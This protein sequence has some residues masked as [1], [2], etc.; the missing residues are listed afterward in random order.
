M[1]TTESTALAVRDL[2]TDA[3]IQ[4]RIKLHRSPGFGLERA[5][6]AALNILFLY[7]QKH[8]LLP[9]DDV[10]LYDGKPFLQIGGVV[11]AMRRHPEYR[12]YACRPLNAADKEAWGYDAGDI[13]IECTIRTDRWGEITA[14]GKVSKDEAAGVQR[15]G[16]RL[17]PVARL[18]PVE[19]AEKRAIAR[20]QR[21]AF[22]LDAVVDEEEFEQAAQTVITERNDP[23]RIAAGAA[24][25]DEVIPPNY[26]EDLPMAITAA[27]ETAPAAAETEPEDAELLQVARER[28]ESACKEAE[29]IGVKGVKQLRWAKTDTI[30][31]IERKTFETEERTR[32]RNNELDLAAAQSS[33][34][35]AFS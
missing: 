25:Y 4:Q 2:L 9:G 33:G 17:N 13:V 8:Q 20:A 31:D 19:M 27:P 14:R 7:C 6:P 5:T 34:Q 35:A 23:A 29:E 3:Q 21:A 16:A 22:G 1:T 32:S 28:N 26:D 11:K 24:K 10:T 15:A 30:E 12:G 18:H